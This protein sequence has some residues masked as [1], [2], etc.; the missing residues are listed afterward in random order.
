MMWDNIVNCKDDSPAVTSAN[1]ISFS[2]SR[3]A[4][5]SR[6]ARYDCNK[7]H[8]SFLGYIGR[9]C[10]LFHWV[11]KLLPFVV[12]ILVTFQNIPFG[13]Q[14]YEVALSAG[15]VSP[16]CISISRRSSRRNCSSNFGSRGWHTTNKLIRKWPSILKI[17]IVVSIAWRDCRLNMNV[18]WYDQIKLVLF[19]VMAVM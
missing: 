4:R 16:S 1:V 14:G 12:W 15:A 19:V 18:T 11:K 3:N 9:N 5:A 7:H 6:I 8:A 2:N 13:A 17:T 10:I